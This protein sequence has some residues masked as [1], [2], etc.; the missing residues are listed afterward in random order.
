MNGFTVGTRRS[1]FTDES[2]M[3]RPAP[4]E[5]RS[6]SLK[7]TVGLSA[8][9]VSSADWEMKRPLNESGFAQRERRPNGTCTPMPATMS[10]ASACV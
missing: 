5:S 8:K 1:S 6:S 3:S 9:P 2:R 10:G 7:A 4:T